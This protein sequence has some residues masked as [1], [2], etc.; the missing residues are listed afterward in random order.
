VIAIRVCAEAGSAVRMFK[1]KE[2]PYGA[3][4][5]D[6]ESGLAVTLDWNGEE[7][8]AFI[9]AEGQ[10]EPTHMHIMRVVKPNKKGN[11]NQ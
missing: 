9:T 4:L 5:I 10:D 1:I 7:V 8:K 2:D 6:V 11:K 3:S